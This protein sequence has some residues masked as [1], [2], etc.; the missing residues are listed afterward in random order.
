M[1]LPQRKRLLIKLRD[2]YIAKLD[3]ALGE[4]DF[5]T[6]NPEEVD[7]YITRIANIDHHIN[8]NMKGI[9]A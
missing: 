8:T 5:T 2:Y 6:V 1:N 9:I 7:K 3:K 4:G